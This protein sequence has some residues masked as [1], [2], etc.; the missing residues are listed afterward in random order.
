MPLSSQERSTRAR[1]AAHE[2]HAKYDS[3]EITA[4]ARAGFLAKFYDQTPADLPHAE[5]LRRAEHLL[6][7]HMQR[8]AVASARARRERKAQAG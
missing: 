4:N 5:R 6:R 8:L 7:A 2:L 1:I 3:R